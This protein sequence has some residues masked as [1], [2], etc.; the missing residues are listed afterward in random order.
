MAESIRPSLVFSLLFPCALEVISCVSRNFPKRTLSTIKIDGGLYF[1]SL[2]ADT[3]I[4]RYPHEATGTL[5][6]ECGHSLARRARWLK[7]DTQH[8]TMM[9]MK[10]KNPHGFGFTTT[11][12]VRLG[13]ILLL[14]NISTVQHLEN[15]ELLTTFPKV[16][17]CFVSKMNAT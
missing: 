1:P 2:L 11:S 4:C 7:P 14:G 17:Q 9:P 8:A 15:L 10:K 3:R 5:G 13:N 6:Q 16:F 12:E